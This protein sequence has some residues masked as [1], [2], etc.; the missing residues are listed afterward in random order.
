MSNT[1]QYMQAINWAIEEVRVDIINMSFGSTT[2]NQDI[3]MAIQKARDTKP[4]PTIMFA[5]ASNSGLNIHRTFPASD[6]N[7]IGIHSLDG[8]GNDN[9]GLNPPILTHRD[10]FGTLG[11]GIEMLW[12]GVSEFKSGSS[13]ATPIGAAVAANLLIWLD[14]MNK[15]R[16]DILDPYVYT[17]LRTTEGVRHMFMRSRKHSESSKIDYVAPWFL[18]ED[19]SQD[20]PNVD[21]D[22]QI[23]SLLKH[24]MKRVEATRGA[25]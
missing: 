23:L 9:G 12:E 21:I 5:A 17:F 4:N 1:V 19:Y 24:G 8:Y 2:I 18:F 20:M 11:L 16:Q 25:K 22:L 15:H 3:E 7:V 14:Y 13:Y 10:N 6:M